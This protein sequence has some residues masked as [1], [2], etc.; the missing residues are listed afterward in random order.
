MAVKFELL[1]KENTAVV[2][3]SHLQ[4]AW[5]KSGS[6]THSCTMRNNEQKEKT[7]RPQQARTSKTKKK[8]P[9]KIAKEPGSEER[10]RNIIF[11]RQKESF[12]YYRDLC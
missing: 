3:A 12:V 7:K 6:R 1:T 5:I 11:L 2:I 8:T 9:S 10:A 4:F